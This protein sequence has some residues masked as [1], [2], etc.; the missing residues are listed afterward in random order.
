MLKELVLLAGV[1]AFA[2][3]Q[4]FDYYDYVDAPQTVL[5]APPP[6]PPVRS[7]PASR[8]VVR[9]PPPQSRPPPQAPV[10]QQTA[11]DPN[12]TPVPIVT[13]VRRIDTKTGGFVYQYAG[14]DGSAKYE[15]R[16][17]NGTVTGNYTFINDLGERE[18]R[19]Y[20]AGVHD[21]TLVDETT[22]PNYVDLGNYELYK[23]LEEPYVHVA[24]AD[25][26]FNS[27]A[28]RSS[29]RA[30]RPSAPRSSGPRSSAPRSSA[31]RASAPR[32]PPPPPLPA[33]TPLDYD[34][35]A[36]H[37]IEPAPLFDGVPAEPL[38]PLPPVPVAPPQPPIRG[39]RGRA[40]GRVKVQS[41]P[42]APPHRLN[43]Q[44]ATD[45]FLDDIINRFS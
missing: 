34:D 2:R 8:P 45:A 27:Q 25:E 6:P 42:V 43:S 12:T 13:D 11:N 37:F 3:A 41:R 35:S 1:L 10:Q 9:G 36:L 21:P 14:A 31:P 20:T 7:R 5:P 16:L 26:S 29:P 38:E 39:G 18:T 33:S 44:S 17:P 15:L 22:D 40:G 4:Q 24:G 30:Q 23:H 28:P 32:P 19:W